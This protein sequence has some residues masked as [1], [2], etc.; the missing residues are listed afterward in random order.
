MQT[1]FLEGGAGCILKWMGFSHYFIFIPLTDKRNSKIY[2]VK[3]FY[4]EFGCIKIQYEHRQTIRQNRVFFCKNFFFY[5]CIM[6]SEIICII[7]HLNYPWLRYFRWESDPIR[8]LCSNEQWKGAALSDKHRYNVA[9]LI[10]HASIAKITA[11]LLSLSYVYF[12]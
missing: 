3:Q 2:K 1:S 10:L 5:I 7:S 8:L 4:W 6:F 9:S 11:Q 12:I